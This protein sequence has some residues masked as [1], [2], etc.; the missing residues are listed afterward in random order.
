MCS[1]QGLQAAHADFWCGDPWFFS[2]FMRALELVRQHRE[3]S[4]RAEPSEK[5][6]CLLVCSNDF[7]RLWLVFGQISSL[8]WL[9][10]AQKHLCWPM[11]GRLAARMVGKGGVSSVR[12]LCWVEAETMAHVNKVFPVF[13]K[14]NEAKLFFSVRETFWL[15]LPLISVVLIVPWFRSKK[16]DIYQLVFIK[17]RRRARNSD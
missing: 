10:S 11:Q 15:N 3:P 14:T 13:I 16:V 12:S 6:S 5:W 1:R 9:P 8:T 7:G 2:F 17:G 4:E